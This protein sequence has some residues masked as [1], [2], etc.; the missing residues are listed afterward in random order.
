M[1]LKDA[2]EAAGF[3]STPSG[4]KHVV[5]GWLERNAHFLRSV[6]GSAFLH[7]L[8][9]LALIYAR[10]A[11][12]LPRPIAALTV[13]LVE[14]ESIPGI[15]PAMMASQKPLAS[16]QPGPS[17]ARTAPVTRDKALSLQQL[18][19]LVEKAHDPVPVVVGVPA[20]ANAF[21]PSLDSGKGIDGTGQAGNVRLKDYI[22]AQV[23]RRWQ[24]AGTHP[25]NG[26]WTISLRL[27]I[28]GDGSVEKAE[29]ILDPR[30]AEDQKYLEVAKSAR[31]AALLSSP[32]RL[33]AG[34]SEMPSDIILDLDSRESTH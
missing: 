15:D 7:A 2:S 22:R 34:M 31:D 21:A 20:A 27:V 29:A 1:T 19:A 12:D 9:I 30:H 16:A 28:D 32:L 5:R 11:H 10:I 13:D 18:F 4:L 23:E 3:A 8:I 25:E 17:V 6:V 33:P 24:I 14:E 26:H